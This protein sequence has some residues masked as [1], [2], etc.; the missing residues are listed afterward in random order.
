V[1]QV[2]WLGLLSISELM[3]AYTAKRH[4]EV[5]PRDVM[6]FM[7]RDEQNPSSIVSC[8]RPRARTPAPCAA[9]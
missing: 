8:L 5:T 4:G 6:E 9:R 2:G 3:P 7:V 1:A